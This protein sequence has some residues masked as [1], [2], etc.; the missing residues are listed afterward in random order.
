MGC[1]TAFLDGDNVR[2]GLNGDLGFSPEDRKENI[3]R[4]AEVARLYFETGQITL[5]TFI[6]PYRSEREFARHAV[7]FLFPNRFRSG[8]KMSNSR[9]GL[10]G[11]QPVV[12]LQLLLRHDRFSRLGLAAPFPC[13]C[14]CDRLKIVHVIHIGVVQGFDPR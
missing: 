9:H 6:S 1:Q 8:S 10:E 5:C 13:V 12:E 2:H 14:I 11:A 4:V 7:E 3:R